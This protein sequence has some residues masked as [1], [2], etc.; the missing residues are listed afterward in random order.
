MHCCPAVYHARRD[1]FNKLTYDTASCARVYQTRA[2]FH[3]PMHVPNY[4]ETDGQ[5]K[6]VAVF[7]PVDNL[8]HV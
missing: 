1:I 7:P 4:L 6:L 8:P 5:L 2:G 3:T